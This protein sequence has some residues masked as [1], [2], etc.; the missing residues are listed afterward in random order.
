MA[1]SGVHLTLSTWGPAASAALPA[2]LIA[3]QTMASAGTSTLV[4]NARCMLTVSASAAIY[5]AY[6][7]NPD[8]TSGPRRYYD[9][10]ATSQ[11]EE[12]ILQQGDRIAWIL[13]A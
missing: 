7:P 1:L 8:A 6:G 3:S 10:A 12:V 4:A 5:Y 13:A 9:P 2:D 11:R